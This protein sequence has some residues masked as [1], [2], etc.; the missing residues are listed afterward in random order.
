MQQGVD[1]GA[2]ISAGVGG[3][4]AS[5]DHHAG[6][7]VDDRE[8]VIFIDNVKRDFFGD[9][10]QGRT[11]DFAEDLDFFSAAE[12]EGGLWGFSVNENFF[13]GDE[14]LDAGA[15]G[16]REMGDEELVEALGGSVGGDGYRCRRM[17]HGVIG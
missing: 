9:G 3:S 16:F 6:G 1:Q 15:T 2:A 13:L 8:I 14:L 10:V 12:A 11:F 5:V 17:F 4:S 7:L